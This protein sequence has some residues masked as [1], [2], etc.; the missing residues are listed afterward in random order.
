LM[1]TSIAKA[2]MMWS[3][4]F[5]SILFLSLLY[6][7]SPAAWRKH[8]YLSP[9][10]SDTQSC[11]DRA[12]PC[13]SLD[14]A[15]AIVLAGTGGA[16]S[17]LVSAAKGNYTLTKTFDFTNVDTFALV[18]EG[19]RSDEVRI[20]CEPNVSLSFVFCQNIALEGFMLQR[21][22][23]W[24]E[25]TVGINKSAHAGQRHQGV[26]FKTA[27]D[28]RYCRNARFTN[29]EI[30]S[31][32]GLGVNFFDVGGVVNFT[33]CVLAD[34]KALDSNKSSNGSLEGFIKEGFVHSGG[35]IYMILNQYGDNI[36]NVTPSQ[37][38]SFQ[39]NNTYLFRDCHFFR[40][41]AIGWN[42]SHKHDIIDDP[43]P[44][45]FSRGGGLA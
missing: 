18:G 24:R 22:G 15:F 23:G 4:I 16:N 28:F 41:E 12:K 25:S 30:S 21:C 37:H 10:G 33:D 31:S 1:K 29:I 8:I 7:P 17:T 2:E 6:L 38:D 20:T 32:P 42:I 5:R 45:Q 43:G 14:T 40:N 35:G 27:L 3:C 36:V 13:K 39:H 19:S 9:S 34:N 44:S 11:G 26:K